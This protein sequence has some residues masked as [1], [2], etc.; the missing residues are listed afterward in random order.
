MAVF[1]PKLAEAGE[2]P[3]VGFR[4]ALWREVS[5]DSFGCAAG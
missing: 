2:K 3:A 5:H 4:A 1:V